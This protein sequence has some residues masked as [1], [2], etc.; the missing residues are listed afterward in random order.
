MSRAIISCKLIYRLPL[1]IGLFIFMFAILHFNSNK[2]FAQTATNKCMGMDDEIMRKC[3]PVGNQKFHSEELQKIRVLIK[4][5]CEGDP[6]ASIPPSIF[7]DKSLSDEYINEIKKGVKAEYDQ[8]CTFAQKS[9]TQETE[10]FKGGTAICEEF[11]KYYDNGCTEPKDQ[12]VVQ[13]IKPVPRPNNNAPPS[14]FSIP[15]IDLQRSCSKA[16]KYFP[17]SRIES[18]YGK[19]VVFTNPG[20]QDTV[21]KYDIMFQENNAK[22]EE[23]YK[24]LQQS[25]LELKAKGVNIP[26]PPQMSKPQNTYSFKGY[27]DSKDWES[28]NVFFINPTGDPSKINSRQSGEFNPSQA[29]KGVEE[30]IF[31]SFILYKSTD[32]AQKVF[33]APPEPP[34]N[35][36]GATVRI[37]KDVKVSGL[38]D[39]GRYIK[40]TSESNNPSFG[41]VQIASYYLSVRKGSFVFFVNFFKESDYSKAEELLKKAVGSAG[42]GID[43]TDDKTIPKK[44]DPTEPKKE[45]KSKDTCSAS[46]GLVVTSYTPKETYAG[47]AGTGGRPLY[48]YYGYM[49]YYPRQERIDLVGKCL[50]GLTASSNDLGID[51]KPAITVNWAQSSADSPKAYISIYVSQYT[52]DGDAKILLKNKYGKSSEITLKVSI[53]GT[54]YLNR[55]FESKKIKFYGSWPTV[56]E[57]VKKL[58][59]EANKML[60]VLKKPNY[61]NLDINTKIYETDMW[62]ERS[63]Q[64]SGIVIQ[65]GKLLGFTQTGTNVIYIVEQ[66]DTD[67]NYSMPATVFHE[68]VHQL[69]FCYEGVHPTTK[70][71][72]VKTNFDIEWWS[73]ISLSIVQCKYL[74]PLSPSSW[75]GGDKLPR[76]G[77]IR[78][79]GAWDL[80]QTVLAVNLPAAYYAAKPLYEDVATMKQHWVYARGDFSKGDAASGSYKQVY[81]DKLRLLEKYGY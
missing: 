67:P 65:K 50:E 25:Y 30:M 17:R 27:P 74:P 32:A 69:H 23:S 31:T 75:V 5:Y 43:P 53:S 1:L 58:E 9:Y 7:L 73:T 12:S 81:L 54:Q 77:F 76:C 16:E 26:E 49:L 44:D 64:L 60:E 29:V 45:E 78:S 19:K 10:R 37:I 22:L 47:D 18:I 42:D 14:G 63:L 48:D 39:E 59:N 68:A 8:M 21:N 70:Q 55:K 80:P 34:Q 66:Y 71:K 41:T 56:N 36:E 6:Y 24:M 40:S 28:C 11:K 52:K 57:G 79:Y 46:S 38:G 72:C 51:G 2:V 62:K 61:D 20:N 35:L 15:T 3:D 13:P 33:N 4:K